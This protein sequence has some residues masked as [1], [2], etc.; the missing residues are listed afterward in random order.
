M[1]TSLVIVSRHSR[2]TPRSL[3]PGSYSHSGSHPSPITKKIASFLS[4]TYVEPILQPFCFHIHACNGGVYPPPQHSDVQT[5]RCFNV[6]PTYPLSFQIL[7]HSFALFCTQQ[8]FNSFLFKRFRTL[9]EKHPGV[10]V[11]TSEGTADKTRPERR[12]RK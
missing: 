9:C 11:G 7:A 10:G 4:C 8:K 2:R 5:C 6:S 3:C 1:L 12:D